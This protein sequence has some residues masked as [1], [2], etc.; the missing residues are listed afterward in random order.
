ML[1]A[2]KILLEIIVRGKTEKEGN[3]LLYG[4][5]LEVASVCF[6]FHVV[7]SIIKSLRFLL[8]VHLNNRV[9]KL[10]DTSRSLLGCRWLY[11]N[12]SF[13]IMKLR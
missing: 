13:N 3:V 4:A 8:S 5:E 12:A 11:S 9:I 10:K 7:L 1:L 6:S 2:V